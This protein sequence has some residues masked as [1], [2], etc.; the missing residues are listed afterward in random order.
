MPELRRDG[1]TDR[2]RRSSH[3]LEVRDKVVDM[4]GGTERCDLCG[5]EAVDCLPVT[6]D[7][8]GETRD[9]NLCKEHRDKVMAYTRGE[10]VDWNV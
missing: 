5:E 1:Q 7:E 9:A 4:M 2:R 6:N 10:E 8:T 3:L